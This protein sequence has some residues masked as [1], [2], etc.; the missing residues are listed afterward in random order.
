MRGSI[1]TKSRCSSFARQCHNSGSAKINEHFWARAI[2]TAFCKA[3]S[4]V[5]QVG[6]ACEIHWND[7]DCYC[8]LCF[9]S[10][11]HIW[12]LRF[13]SVFVKWP[14]CVAY[15]TNQLSTP[16]MWRKY[17]CLCNLWYFAS[18]GFFRIPGEFKMERFQFIIF[19]EEY[20]SSRRCEHKAK[21]LMKH[22]KFCKL[23]FVET[24]ETYVSFVW[25]SADQ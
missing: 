13:C 4:S 7:Y 22:L 1:W 17:S 19:G 15:T 25:M 3:I 16:K 9:T 8:L 20:E 2:H 24:M 23:D 6:S 5:E 21:S 12:F 11:G 18:V 10:L 14:R